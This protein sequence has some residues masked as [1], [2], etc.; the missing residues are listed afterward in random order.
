MSNKIVA[1]MCGHGKS[2]NGS[3]DSGHTYVHNGKKYTEAA[4]MLPI[5]KAAVKY[6]RKQSGI[7]V[8]SDAD[9]NNNRNMVADVQWANSMKTSLYVSIHCNSIKAR[10]GVM[11]LYTS[12]EG[13]KLANYLCKQIKLDLNCSSRGIVKK[14]GLYELTKTNCPA[15]ILETGS[16]KN[17]LNLLIKKPDIY[18][19]AIAKAIC[20]YLGITFKDTTKVVNKE[21]NLSKAAKAA[22]VVYKA[23]IESKCKHQG[24]ATSLSK[25]KSLHKTTCNASASFVLQEAGILPKGK[26]IGHKPKVSGN[27]V[28]KKNTISK[29]MYGAKYLN[30]DKCKIVKIG[31]TYSH[32]SAE[33]KKKGIVY[34]Q[35]SNACVNAGNGYIYSTNNASSQKKNGV[36]IKD[37]CKGGYCFN[38]PILYAI[39]PIN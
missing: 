34:I 7:T 32:M 19:K 1:V 22:D 10:K 29:A 9:I 2:M 30:K 11:P 35:N 16:L 37:K 18:G 25:M 15:V 4:L 31:T 17:D 24:G 8:I 23:V 39:V 6:L 33:Y 3:W 27:A 38:S 14:T 20:K 21:S 26:T 36:Y 28:A 12:A 13:K 5:T